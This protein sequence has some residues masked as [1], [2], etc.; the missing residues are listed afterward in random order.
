M[1]YQHHLQ[2]RG[3]TLIEL[4]IVS[5]ILAVL[6]GMTIPTFFAQLPQHRV[7][8]AARQVIAD[9]MTA[10]RRAMSQ[11]TPVHVVFTPPYSYSIWTDANAN[12]RRDVDEVLLHNVYRYRTKL[13]A[14][15]NPIFH[16]QG[17]V[18]NFAT[19]TLTQGPSATSARCIRLSIAG[20]ITHGPCRA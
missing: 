17:T 19:I 16:P 13:V 4:L 11:Q 6:A 15:N 9:L 8:R 12:G 20:R 3:F 2:P 14:N 18:T 1:Q 7:N 5:A 10:R